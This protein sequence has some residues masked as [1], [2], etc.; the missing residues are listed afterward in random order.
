VTVAYTHWQDTR[1]QTTDKDRT[2]HT[3][4]GVTYDTVTGVVCTNQDW[5]EVV[6][7]LGALLLL[8]LPLTFSPPRCSSHPTMS[9]TSAPALRYG[10]NKPRPGLAATKP[11][12]F[13]D[14][15]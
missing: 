8:A 11:S 1:Q 6:F 15:L 3:G 5:G 2:Q 9:S 4:H 10:L 13:D 12:V 14:S 7:T